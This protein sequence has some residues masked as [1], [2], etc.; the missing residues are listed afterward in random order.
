MG[1]ALKHRCPRCGTDRNLVYGYQYCR[2]CSTAVAR[3]MERSG[4]LTPRVNTEYGELDRDP[5]LEPR[6][7]TRRYIRVIH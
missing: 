5:L 3:E 2:K 7:L 1:T 4:Y 6:D